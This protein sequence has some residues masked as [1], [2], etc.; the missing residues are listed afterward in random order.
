MVRSFSLDNSHQQPIQSL[1]AKSNHQ[2]P[3]T[4]PRNIIR[5]PSANP[6]KMA[7]PITPVKDDWQFRNGILALSITFGVFFVCKVTYMVVQCYSIRKIQ[8]KRMAR[9]A[10][11]RERDGNAVRR[12]WEGLTRP[13]R[14]YQRLSNDER[15]G[16]EM[17]RGRRREIE[18]EIYRRRESPDRMDEILRIAVGKLRQPPGYGYVR[19]GRDPTNEELYG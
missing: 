5:A 4:S 13:E 6:A 15:D 10:R 16:L 1:S 8:Q 18:E 2:I 17:E 14:A 19:G 9:H 7:V 3:S 12:F 11:R